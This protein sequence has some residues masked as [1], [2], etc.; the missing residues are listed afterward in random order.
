METPPAFKV[1]RR[2]R[3]RLKFHRDKLENINHPIGSAAFT[4]LVP[5]EESNLTSAGDIAFECY[6]PAYSALQKAQRIIHK[7]TVKRA[8]VEVITVFFISSLF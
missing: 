8:S 3:Q 6:A 1:S 4:Q 5:K 2:Q 7:N